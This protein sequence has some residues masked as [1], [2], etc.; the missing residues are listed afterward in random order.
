MTTLVALSGGLDS[1]WVLWHLLSTTK[2]AVVAFH[3]NLVC[4]LDRHVPEEEAADKVVVWC[5]KNV[6]PLEWYKKATL[7][8]GDLMAWTDGPL[9]A[10]PAV[11]AM[12]NHPDTDTIATGRCPDECDGFNDLCADQ[13]PSL[14][15]FNV[16]AGVAWKHI[17]ARVGKG[18]SRNGREL[19]II[20]P[21][22]DAGVSKSEMRNQ[23]PKEL[24][25]MTWSCHAPV[26]TFAGHRPC[27]ECRSCRLREGESP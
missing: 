24:Y 19:K 27:N 13:Q 25:D 8:M 14:P 4:V 12:I 15:G 6:R 7:D 10:V 20:E 2:T 23:M 17:F 21:A 1:S 26:K 18:R 3:L 16:V 9:I 22:M 5:E 11:A